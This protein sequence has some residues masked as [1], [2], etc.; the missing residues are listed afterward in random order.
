MPAFAP[1]GSSFSHFRLVPDVLQEK[2]EKLRNT[3]NVSAL[4]A[5]FALAG[6]LQMNF[7]INMPPQTVAVFGF[8]CTITTALRFV[9]R[10]SVRPQARP[11]CPVFYFPILFVFVQH[12]RTCSTASMM[13]T[14]LLLAV[15]IKCGK[16]FVDEA[17]QVEFM[18]ECMKVCDP[19][20]EF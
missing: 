4:I 11:H 12:P 14:S 16:T 15:V 19:S 18:H 10:S 8:F 13:M 2:S 5:G 1:M 9:R 3:A 17:A 7:T 6:M 20:F